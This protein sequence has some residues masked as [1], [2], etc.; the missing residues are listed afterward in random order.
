MQGEMAGEGTEN[1]M[2]LQS[3]LT[4]GDTPV[5]GDVPGSPGVGSFEVSM[6]PGFGD[7]FRTEW[8]QAVP[9][10]DYVIKTRITGLQAGTRYYYRLLYGRDTTA[11]G[12]GE[13][14]AFRTLP[15]KDRVDE[16]SF[17][18]VTGMNYE[19]FH[20]GRNRSRTSGIPQ[21][22]STAYLGKDKDLGYPALETI[23]AMEPDFFVGTGDN[24]YYDVPFLP[25]HRRAMTEAELRKKWHEQFVQPR[26]VRLF[27][28]VPTYWEKDDHDYRY[29]DSDPYGPL[30]RERD[31]PNGHLPTHELGIRVFREQVPVVDATDG[32]QPTYRTYR[33]SRLLQIWFVEGRD[34]RSPNRMP[35]GPCKTI[36]GAEQKAWLERTL[37]DSDA[38]F[39]IL[40]SPTPIV[41]PDHGSKRDNHANPRGFRHE[42]QAF[43]DWLS[44]HGLLDG[45]FYVV[46]GDR[47]WQYHSVHPSGLEEF[48]CGALVDANSIPG[49][50]PGDPK[51]TDPESQVKQLYIYEQPTGGFL[52]VTIGAEGEANRAT[53]EFS[54]FDEKGRLL[55][56]HTK[57]GSYR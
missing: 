46:C 50:R 26:F 25:N 13:V 44:R 5:E 6:D 38:L 45:H 2:I 1:S 19:Y 17:V 52:K 3:R 28:R 57:L 14:C 34:Y 31:K 22:D 51:S 37:L 33:M 49:K 9:E 30:S 23:L 53:A 43:L 15:G 8:V 39:K 54:F 10:Q 21:G 36:W 40:V 47:H 41:G 18:V 55:Y 12:K 32:D 27:S 20:Y 56:T 16:V 4:S 29:N 48:S 42:G 7:S 11:V 35:D 24:V